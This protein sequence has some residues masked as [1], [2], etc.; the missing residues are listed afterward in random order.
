MN[1]KKIKR[2][3]TLVYVLRGVLVGLLLAA[4][5]MAMCAALDLIWYGLTVYL[6]IAAVI[7][8]GCALLF[9]LFSFI[10]KS[11]VMKPIADQEKKYG[12]SFDQADL[13]EVG[14]SGSF[15][16]SDDWLVHYERLRTTV[17]HKDDIRSIERA[18]TGSSAKKNGIIRI[19]DVQ[20]NSLAN[21]YQVNECDLEE[22]L[23]SWLHPYIAPAGNICPNC[24][25]LNEEGAQF[26]AACGTKLN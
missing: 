22:Q 25:F 14:G 26:C 1:K 19:T 16:A 10:K 23:N 15:F 17:W 3:I 24:S 11:S 5:F 18:G 2:Q 4:A 6:I 12:A 21:Y 9:Y 8:I 20:G 13:R 7:V